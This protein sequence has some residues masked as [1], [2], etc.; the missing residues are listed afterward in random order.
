MRRVEQLPLQPPLA[1][2]AFWE[3]DDQDTRA[4]AIPPEES[5]EV[6]QVERS[7]R[8]AIALLWAKSMLTTLIMIWVWR[9]ARSYDGCMLTFE[10]YQSRLQ[11]RINQGQQTLIAGY[12]AAR[13]PGTL[14]EALWYVRTLTRTTLTVD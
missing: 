14:I 7:L 13:E 10:T 5:A 9:N 1:K 4:R 11:V 6:D 12:A 3:A 2:P 8:K